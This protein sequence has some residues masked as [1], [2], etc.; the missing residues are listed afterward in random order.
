MSDKRR[1]E[2]G[3]DLLM[4]S[5]PLPLTDYREIVLAHGS[6]GKL[7]QQLMQKVVLPQFRNKLLE[8]LH[9]GAIFSVGGVRLAFSTDSYVV[10]P[11]FFPGG[12]I[13]KLAVHGTVNDLAMCGARPLHLS[14]GFILEEGLPMDDFWRVVQS[15][16]EAAD[17]AGVTLVTGDT[18]VVDR[19]KADKIFINTSGIGQVRDGID[20]DPK[21]ARPGDKIILSGF[22]AVHGIAIM[23]VREGLEFETEI[24]SDTAPLNGLTEAIFATGEEVHVLR[25]PTR[26]GLTSALAE[27]A[28][29]AGVGM[30]LD[31]AS[32]PISEEVKGACE[33]LGLDPLYVANEG[34][35]VAVVPAEAAEAILAA[36]KNH[37]LGEHAAIIGEIAADHPGFVLMKTR[38]GGSRVVDMLSGEQLPRIC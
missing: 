34:K 1:P 15:M 21:R 28:Q 26:G 35:L 3:G 11:I 36:M 12:D 18:K 7:S 20:I 33:I 13:G 16:R 8:P 4:A 25:D 9:D 22:I 23:S 2:E 27:I 6:G 30:L 10:S 19:G 17:A 31:E 14:V 32:I 5:C 29:S 37:S 24:A 38:I